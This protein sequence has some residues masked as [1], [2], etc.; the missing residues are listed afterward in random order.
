MCTDKYNIGDRVHHEKLS[1]LHD[2]NGA[3]ELQRMVLYPLR[4]RFP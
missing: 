3:P 1:L 4:R 2:S